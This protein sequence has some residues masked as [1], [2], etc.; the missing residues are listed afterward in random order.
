MGTALSG[1]SELIRV[2][3]IDFF[4][5]AILLNNLV[6][7]DVPMQ[8]LNTRFSGVTWRDIREAKKRRRCFLGKAAALQA[9]WTYVTPDTIVVG[10]GLHNDLRSLRWIHPLVVDSFMIESSIRKKTEA[11][12]MRKLE[13]EVQSVA[14][15][16][17]QDSTAASVE[18]KLE[19]NQSEAATNLGK[20]QNDA[21][22][23]VQQDPIVAA[24]AESPEV[25]SQEK[26][27]NEHDASGAKQG[28][29]RSRRDR[30]GNLS[31]KTLMKKRLDRDIQMGDGKTGHDSLEDAIAARD[32]IHWHITHPEKREERG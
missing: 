22:N 23:L 8:H 3:L 26:I 31:L 32:L 7:P 9:V 30:P 16:T 12:Q 18:L 15:R 5:G 4:S 24:D 1:D 21:E 6:E 10:H 25:K 14:Q 27:H 13:E 20:E 11:E 29:K 19:Q 28:K 17:C 2:T